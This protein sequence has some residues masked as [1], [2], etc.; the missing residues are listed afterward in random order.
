MSA[1]PVRGVY[2]SKTALFNLHIYFRCN[3]NVGSIHNQTQVRP[4]LESKI[5]VFITRLTDS[6]TTKLENNCSAS[7]YFSDV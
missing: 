6:G 5:T 7:C 3:N 2:Y 1:Y 4:H